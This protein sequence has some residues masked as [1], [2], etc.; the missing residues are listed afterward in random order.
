MIAR[1][2]TAWV[3]QV[4]GPKPPTKALKPSDVTICGPGFAAKTSPEKARGLAKALAQGG[5]STR[6]GGRQ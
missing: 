3:H 2:Y 6:I 4:Y 5:V 1:D